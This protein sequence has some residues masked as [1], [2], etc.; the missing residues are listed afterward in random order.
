MTNAEAISAT[1]GVLTYLQILGDGSGKPIETVPPLPPQPIAGHEVTQDPPYSATVIA[2]VFGKNWNGSNDIGDLDPREPD[3]N[4]RGFF[5]DPS[6]NAPY[7]THVETLPGISLPR[8]VLLSTFLGVD[9]WQQIGIDEAWSQYAADLREWVLHHQPSADADSGGKYT[10]LG[11]PF[12]D[13][14]P[15]QPGAGADLT[16]MSA[17]QLMTHGSALITYRVKVSGVVIPIRGWDFVHR[18]LL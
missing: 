9:I 3:G 18:R 1:Q 14:G 7:V 17:H 2:T 13:A 16:Y 10:A 15:K 12:V 8:E 4:A 5:I 11:M 6:T